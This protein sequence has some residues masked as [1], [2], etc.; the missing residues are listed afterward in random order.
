MY[1]YELTRANWA[2]AQTSSLYIYNS[3]SLFI[4]I[5]MCVFTFIVGTQDSSERKSR[6]ATARLMLASLL[7]LL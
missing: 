3:K 2:D 5:Y 1:E 6:S 7:N 4:Y